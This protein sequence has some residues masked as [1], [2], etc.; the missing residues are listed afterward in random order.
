MDLILGPAALRLSACI[1]DIALVGCN[2]TC[3]F[4]LKPYCACTNMLLHNVTALFRNRHEVE[5]G[6]IQH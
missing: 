4:L 1:L 6:L 5:V 3:L 2:K